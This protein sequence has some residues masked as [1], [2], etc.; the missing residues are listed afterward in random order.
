MHAM[1]ALSARHIQH[2]QGASDLEAIEIHHHQQA[3]STYQ[4][5]FRD[6]TI[7]I[8]QDAVLGTSLLLCFYSSSLLDF[9]PSTNIGVT[10]TCLTFY[11]GI[12]SIVSDAPSIAHN[13]LF[14]SIVTPPLFLRNLYPSIGPGA[15]LLNLLNTLPATPILV[16]RKDLYI[17]R[18]ESLTLYMSTSTMQGLET[19]AI[20][21]LILCFLRWQSFCPPEFIALVRAFDPVA[22]IILAHFYAAGGF[23]HSRSGNIFWWWEQKPAYMVRKITKYLGPQWRLWMEWPNSMIARYGEGK[24]L[25]LTAK[26]TYKPWSS[27]VDPIDASFFPDL[28]NWERLIAYT[29]GPSL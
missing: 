29:Q 23:V 16:A 4:T 15:K 18:I 8:N 17:E 3:L 28:Y 25:K 1:L 7:R 5:A 26:D 14:R 6:N 24:V 11:P 22:I 20:H 21:E 13:G 12:R 2:L 9:E 27:A 19:G 10:D